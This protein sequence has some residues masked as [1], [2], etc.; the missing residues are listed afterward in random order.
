MAK[1]TFSL[2]LQVS[3]IK[4]G[5]KFIAYAPALDLSTF[6]NS[7]EEAKK[8]FTEVVEIFFEEVSKA[9]TLEEVLKDLGWTKV[10]S[11]KGGWVPPTVVSQ[12]SQIFQVPLYN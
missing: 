4:E 3:I 12:G 8:R 9:R 10:Q 6:G 2:N 1:V 5:D 11:K 7:L